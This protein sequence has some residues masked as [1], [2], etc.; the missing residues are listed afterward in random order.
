MSEDLD[1]ATVQR[2][3]EYLVQT[4]RQSEL[5]IDTLSQRVKEAENRNAVLEQEIQSQ[6]SECEYFSKLSEQYKTENSKKWRLAER[7]DWKALVDSVQRDRNRLQDE[8]VRTELALQEANS[9]IQ[10]Q[11]EL[12][13]RAGIEYQG[14]G[15]GS[16]RQ[17]SLPPPPASPG[18]SQSSSSSVPEVPPTP[19][20]HNRLLQSEL[21]RTTVQMEETKKAAEAERLSH[22]KEIGRLRSE[23][24]NL[25][26]PQKNKSSS[27]R[28]FPIIGFVT[29]SLNN[30]LV[31]YPDK[32][33]SA[34]VGSV[35]VV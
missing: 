4:R 29:A 26:E 22:V 24:R 30:L 19:R 17:L 12:L 6:R 31:P 11:K 21:E 25:K 33:Q 3:R 13:E 27:G 2:L 23:V 15:H 9:E 28:A 5:A 18:Q 7:D 8:L 14:Q 32:R 35:Q 10:R 1:G 20:T 34:H 16:Q